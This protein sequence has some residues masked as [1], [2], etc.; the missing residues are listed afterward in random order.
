MTNLLWR[1]STA[2]DKLVI[3]LAALIAFATGAGF[4]LLPVLFARTISRFS[5]LYNPNFQNVGE[6][7]DSLDIET[8]TQEVQVTSKIMIGIGAAI[9]LSTILMAYLQITTARNIASNIRKMYFKALMRQDVS[10]YHENTPGTLTARVSSIDTIERAIGQTSIELV[11]DVTVT[12]SGFFIA[13]FSSWKMT[14]V[15]FAFMPV[16]AVSGG[17]VA[18]F[19]NRQAKRV[20]E[21]L[22]DASSATNDTFSSIRSVLA[23]EGKNNECMIYKKSLRELYKFQVR[24]A[25]VTGTGTG[26]LMLVLMSTFSVGF[27][28]GNR[29]VI[30]EQVTLD[31]A[32]S[33]SAMVPAVFSAFR[34]VNAQKR[35]TAASAAA[36]YVNEVISREPKIDPLSDEGETIKN[37]NGGI[38]FK[39]VNFKHQQS[40]ELESNQVLHNL[41]FDVSPGSLVGLCGQSGR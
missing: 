36:F 39:N 6:E 37:F 20:N 38:Q 18:F 25:I 17:I 27:I 21:A 31:R 9:A 34:I 4:P 24:R 40:E 12:F 13:F 33:A 7:E 30:S 2:K 28:I 15:I 10:W 41:S 32:I 5:K 19:S 14:L 1:T 16:I 11:R 23:F 35:I 3:F 22:G 29:L 26:F 8:V